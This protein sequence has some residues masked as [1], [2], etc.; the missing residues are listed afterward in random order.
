MPALPSTPRPLEH[1]W[2][3]SAAQLPAPDALGFRT[4][5]GRQY[6]DVPRGGIVHI[7]ADPDTGLY[8]AKLP[9]ELQASG[10]VLVRDPE[11][12]LW[13]SLDDV[14]PTTY[15]L[16]NTRL[17]AFRTSLDFTGSEPGSDGLYRH[18]G[19]LYVVIE[20]RAYQVLHDLE[21]SSPQAAVMRVVRT[22][23]PVALDNRNL[24]V[25]TRPGRS[26]PVVYDVLDGWVGTKVPGAGGMMRSEPDRPARQGLKD[27]LL[28]AFDRLRSPESRAADLYP[29]LDT[30][31]IKALVRSL[32]DDVD[33]GLARRKTEYKTLKDQLKSWITQSS[34][35][36]TPE[37]TKRW[38]EQVAQEIKRCWRQQTGTT[39]KLQP[40][41]GT[42]PALNADFSHVR[43]L[44]LKDITW[45]D[46]VDTFLTGFS[47][48]EHLTVTRSTLDKLP[49]AVA[50]MSDL[51]T[52]NLSSNR[53]QLNEQTSAKL[54]AL[55][56]LENI[57]LSSNP[58][59]TMPDF[60][61]MS[62]LKA[63]NLSNTQL[64]QWPTGLQHQ[65]KLEIVDLRNNQLREVP[66]ANLNPT[67]DQLETIARING[68]T[69]L[70]GNRFPVGYWKSF[71]LYWQRVA[72]E[73]PDLSTTTRPGA[74]RIDG[75]IPEVAIVQRMYPDKNE[76]AAREY[77]IGLGDGAEAQIARR[78]QAFDLLETQ[79]ERYIADSQPGSSSTANAEKIQVKRLARI[80]KGCWLEGSE[81][82]L[83]LP[84]VNG[85]L[86]ALTA[87]FSHVKMLSMD[88][89]N[90][91]DASNTFLSN[92]PNLESLSI[93][94]SQVERLPPS[95]GEM[96]KLSYLSL[97]SSNMTL[98]AQ[99]ASTLS[100]LSQLKV[101]DLSNNPLQIAPDFSAMSELNSV[102]LQ[103][104]Q[105]GQWPTGL[106]DKTALTGIDLSNNRLRE[107]PQANLNPAPEHLETV[108]RINAVTRLEGNEF[109]SQYW[110]KFDGYWR[111]L[112]E[113][114]PE[115]MAPAYSKAFDSENSWAQRYR[116]LYPQ[117]GIKECREYIWSH[118]KGVFSRK[119]NGLEQ[120]F[121]VL[122]SQLDAWVYSGGGNRQGYI[123]ANQ[124]QIN[125]QTR[126]HRTKARDRIISCWRREGNQKLAADGT[127][128]GWELNLG[129]LILPTL[130]DLSVDFSHVGS[131]R[132]NNMNLT[133]SPE[134][135]L[136][137]FRHLR[138]LDMSHN[139]LRD[140]PPAVGEMHA[141]TRLFL[142]KNQLQLNTETAR[143]LFSRTTLRLL[144]LHDNPQLGV[145]PDFSL[146]SDIR[147]ASL[148]NT[149][150]NAWPTGLFDQPRLT[151]IDL[152]NNQI[153][154]IPDFV[155][156]PTADRLAHSV[157]VNSGTLITNNPLSDATHVQLATYSERLTAAGTP[158]IREPNLLTTSSV[159]T[160]Q[161]EP[162][163]SAV[164]MHPAWITGLSADQVSARRE[165][166]RMLREQ[167]GSD[168]FFNIIRSRIGH[169]DFRRQ[170]WEVI[171]V[172]TEN[173]P[174]SRAL[175]RELFDRACEAGCTDL[176]A[177]TFTDLQILAISHKARIQAKLD[178]NGTPLVDLS[179]GL[180]RLRQVDDIA[181]ADLESSRAMAS[182]PTTSAEQRRFHLNRIHD[183]HEMTMAYRFGLKDR[184]Q[185]PFQPETLSYIGMANVHPTM[186]DA[187][188][189]KVVALDGSPEEFQALVSMDFWQD[190]ITHKYQSQ[191]DANRQPFQD[192][193]A[194]LDNQKFQGQLAES[195]YNAQSDDVQA[196]LAITEAT[197]I[198]AVTRQ[199]LQL[200]S[201]IDGH[202]ASNTS[203]DELPPTQ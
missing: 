117:K 93:A 121:S 197:L 32:G 143:I 165:Q 92:F 166:W 51:S 134:G 77:L 21:A 126:S 7:T 103:N 37:P 4:F 141:M 196:Q 145:L 104:T 171:D 57:D 30:E 138:W 203:G 60:S 153:T 142:Q 106:L 186:L 83:R 135:F 133:A 33:G 43:T 53:I 157:Q 2:L 79:L 193:Q 66:Q 128:I 24:Y 164:E 88:S 63:L 194:I 17:E 29:S 27:R 185:L 200:P 11:S 46:T 111:R 65:A 199:E 191:F 64:D 22:E 176:A 140:L 198:Q 168:G 3:A 23:D 116:E 86:P 137:R 78:I 147:T 127:P 192:R 129:R 188:Y 178:L 174:Q 155:T 91:S 161:P 85:A 44:D 81:T 95:I 72:A 189:R 71:E 16:T 28:S 173:N 99:S 15:P 68:V 123:R 132:L 10:P 1:Y 80:I 25:A 9:S 101:V 163:T 94:H 82:T 76:G 49:A 34:A 96:K 124:L 108:A 74:F 39:L 114:H 152:S 139:R 48:L 180:F 20:D 131:L 160:R 47:R 162:A 41:N 184:L 102:N 12:T 195:E 119:L 150:I 122:T 183:P 148:A 40:G 112:N 98:D 169:P 182:D 158:L 154:T 156:A 170:A 54:S 87:D 84:S 109:P 50:E 52:L 167:Q 19:K 187:A 13:Y 90:W 61:A 181:A 69:L 202:L 14:E 73:Y 125:A 35:S 113:A 97:T 6:V 115:L 175:R 18:D 58:L 151:D 62:E 89:V 36:S 31:Q 67:A 100:A 146:I 105:I 118:E 38:A 107:V 70:E 42:L 159:H 5:K 110:R 179:K 136:T 55:S 45:S 201:T 26:E 177:A 8:R 172:I 149:G 130:P 75:D 56:K 59:G 120:E 144:W 190:F